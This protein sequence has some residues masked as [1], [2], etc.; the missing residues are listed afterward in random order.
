MPWHP[1]VMTAVG[2]LSRPDLVEE[3]ED[4]AEEAQEEEEDHEEKHEKFTVGC[5]NWGG[6]IERRAKKRTSTTSTTCP[7]SFPSLRRWETIR[8]NTSQAKSF[9]G[10][11]RRSAG[12]WR[13]HTKGST[14]R[15]I[16]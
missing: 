11:P 2:L 14:P 15:W 4:Q 3:V 8:S 7:A 12:R 1:G 16:R 6:G 13:F 5:F 9:T 10:T